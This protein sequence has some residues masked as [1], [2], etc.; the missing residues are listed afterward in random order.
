M[1]L[2]FVLIINTFL[3]FAPGPGTELLKLWQLPKWGEQ[4]RCLLLGEWDDFSEVP[5]FQRGVLLARVTKHMVNDWNFRSLPWPCLGKPEGLL[6]EAITNSHWFN[7]LCLCDDSSIKIPKQ[8][9]DSFWVE[10]HMQIWGKW[11]SESVKFCASPPHTLS[12]VSPSICC[13][14][15]Y[16]LLQ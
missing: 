5:P 15:V 4:S 7:Q 16:Y 9:L 11:G 1:T 14:W 8:G 6:F 12:Y 10:E 2:W 3:V 13:S